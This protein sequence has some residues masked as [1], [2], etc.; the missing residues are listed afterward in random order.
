MGA[1]ETGVFQEVLKTEAGV[2]DASGLKAPGPETGGKGAVTVD[3]QIRAG[4]T[5]VVDGVLETGAKV[6]DLPVSGGAEEEEAGVLTVKGKDA[7]ALKGDGAATATKVGEALPGP[8]GDAA[9]IR[10]RDI[11]DSRLQGEQQANTALG[12][13]ADEELGSQTSGSNRDG[14]N[15]HRNADQMMAAEGAIPKEASL[16]ANGPGSETLYSVDQGKGAAQAKTAP[17]VGNPN[18]TVTGSQSRAEVHLHHIQSPPGGRGIQASMPS[19][20]HMEIHEPDLGR[21]HWNLTMEE[22]RVM[23]KAMVDTTRL[24]ELLRSHQDFLQDGFKKAGLEMEGFDVWVGSGSRDSSSS[25]KQSQTG[26]GAR[27]P[28][29]GS[30]PD[31]SQG[32]EVRGDTSSSQGLDLFV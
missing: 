8:E 24:Q 5:G 9:R 14:A 19:Q 26:A 4:D 2:E 28:G 20:V 11:A 27:E 15:A 17:V 3:A 10:G 32:E 30:E 1:G 7:F 16:P 23:A 18:N 22:G 12:E 6:A 21:M 29:T 31:D 13:G 25:L